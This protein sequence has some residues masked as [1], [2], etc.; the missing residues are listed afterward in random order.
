CREGNQDCYP[1]TITV[2]AGL[3]GNYASVAAT[4]YAALRRFDSLA[5]DV[6]LAEG[7]E[8]RGLGL[9]VAN[10]LRKAAGGK[11]IKAD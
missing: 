2:S 5:V 10:R 3:E 9:T 11:I 4:L 6:I 7:V 8:S 1:G